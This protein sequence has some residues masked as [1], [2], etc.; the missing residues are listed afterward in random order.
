MRAQWVEIQSALSTATCRFLWAFPFVAGL[1][2]LCWLLQYSS[3]FADWPSQASANLPVFVGPGRQGGTVRVV[4]DVLGGAYVAWSGETF[5]LFA[6]H[7]TAGGAIATGWPT[8]GLTVADSAYYSG[9]PDAVS[10][11]MGGV[12]LSWF[13]LRSNPLG[14]TVY[15][16]RVTAAAASL[17][18]AGGAPLAPPHH[19]FSDELVVGCADNRVG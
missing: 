1:T 2:S 16:Q 10:D 14:H 8:L 15:A 7:L 5:G 18:G 6:Q 17:W 9:P 3:S 4:P 19:A 12:V 13:D 11:L